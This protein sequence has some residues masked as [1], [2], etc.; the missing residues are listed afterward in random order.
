MY[1]YDAPSPTSPREAA[2]LLGMEGARRRGGEGARRL[3]RRG[4]GKALRSE[5]GYPYWAKDWMQSNR[6]LLGPEA[7]EG[8]DVHHL[9]LIVMVAAFNH[10]HLIMVV[11]EKTKTS[12]S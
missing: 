1:E 3:R 10:Q 7:G 8:G 6:T 5:L 9:V 4:R 12:R 2:R 11:M